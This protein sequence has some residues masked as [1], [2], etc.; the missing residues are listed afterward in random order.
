MTE[1]LPKDVCYVR[2]IYPK[3]NGCTCEEGLKR[4]LEERDRSLLA[5]LAAENYSLERFLK[6]QEV[7]EYLFKKEQKAYED[8]LGRETRR[9]QFVRN[10]T[11]Y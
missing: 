8:E 9:N 2:P 1:E 3:R 11:S 6:D 10:F 7:T 5:K 4:I